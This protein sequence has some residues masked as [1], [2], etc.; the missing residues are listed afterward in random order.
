MKRSCMGEIEREV[1]EVLGTVGL[2]QS[3]C[4]K[5]AY[6]LSKVEE[7]QR[8]EESTQPGF[9]KSL[10][11]AVARR[12]WKAWSANTSLSD[13]EKAGSSRSSQGG[14]VG[15]TAFLLR[16]GELEEEVPNSRLVISA[17]TIGFSYALG[18]IIPLIPYFCFSKVIYAFYTSIGLTGVTLIV[19]GIVKA[20][21]T[22][23]EIGWRGYTWSALSTLAIGGLAAG[24]AYGISRAIE[25][26]K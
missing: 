19:F 5:V 18:G 12:P 17:L 25:S 3:A 15:L 24:S 16:F 9:G 11:D 7:V 14:D 2:D 21:F 4:R 8:Q 1:S 23:S 10:A 13:T 20:Y 26:S 22:G 6:S